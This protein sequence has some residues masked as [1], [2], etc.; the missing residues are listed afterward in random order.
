MN[1]CNK[2]QLKL[3]TVYSYLR[4]DIPSSHFQ[5]FR[6]KNP[7]SISLLS[8]RAPWFHQPNNIWRGLKTTEHLFMQFSSTSSYFFHVSRNIFLGIPFPN[9]LGLCFPWIWKTNFDTYTI[10]QTVY[11]IVHFNKK[12]GDKKVSGPNA[13]KQAPIHFSLYFLGACDFDL[14]VSFPSIWIFHILK[15]FISCIYALTVFYI[16]LMNESILSFLR[17]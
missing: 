7:Q 14:L 9:T 3:T 15:G 6:K 8:H 4:L 16:L 2:T 10:Q 1:V 12:T 17:I 5:S 13:S 11:I